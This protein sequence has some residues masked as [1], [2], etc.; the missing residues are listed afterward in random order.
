MY[1]SKLLSSLVKGC[2]AG[3]AV[4]LLALP[5]QAH[6]TRII[7]NLKMTVGNNPEPVFEDG[8]YFSDLFLNQ[9]VN[10]VDVP[11]DTN[12]GADISGLEAYVF[13]ARDDVPITS[14]N[15]PLII[16]KMKLTISQRRGEINRYG[17]QMKFTHDGAIGYYYTGTI[18]TKDGTVLPVDEVFVCGGGTQSGV[19][20]GCIQDPI[21]FP[22]NLDGKGRSKDVNGYRDNDNLS[23]D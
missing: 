13:M 20:F 11:I 12:D 6:E 16:K 2:A 1:E 10:G 9:I 15:D 3:F 4:L 21:A 22:G 18:M 5:V 17:M 7:G 19:S 8:L 23:L 14:I